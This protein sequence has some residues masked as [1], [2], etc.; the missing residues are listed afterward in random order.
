[1]LESRITLKIKKQDSRPTTKQNQ[2]RKKLNLIMEKITDERLTPFI[3]EH[4]SKVCSGK[5][6]EER[7]VYRVLNCKIVP[8]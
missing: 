8:W 6:G 1:M 5:N 4:Y 3:R 7:G 2:F